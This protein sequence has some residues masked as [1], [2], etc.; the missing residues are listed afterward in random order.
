MRKGGGDNRE[1]AAFTPTFSFKRKTHAGEGG[2][3]PDFL[4]K[5]NT[6]ELRVVTTRRHP[7]RRRGEKKE[8][9]KKKDSSHVF[10]VFW[11][12]SGYFQVSCI[13]L[14]KKMFYTR[15]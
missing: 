14:P 13:P 3:L 5:P 4:K 1:Q 9:T 8:G 11:K 12:L 15:Y 10:S 7:C 2:G 6:R